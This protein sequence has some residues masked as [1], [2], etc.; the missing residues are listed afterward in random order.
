MA[1]NERLSRQL[2]ELV[3]QMTQ[4]TASVPSRE[5]AEVDYG[6][7]GDRKSDRQSIHFPAS[8]S[9]ATPV[10]P[11]KTALK[12]SASKTESPAAVRTTHTLFALQLPSFRSVKELT[13]AWSGIKRRSGNV[14]AGLEPRSFAVRDPQIGVAY[15]LIVGPMRN[16]GDAA[17]RCVR[18][19]EI[20]I[21]C[22]T[23]VFEGE[24]LAS[25]A[26]N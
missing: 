17:L 7:S 25:V 13:G 10:Q 6:V 11:E 9:S 19:G 16:A 23:T 22:E 4:V 14:L 12:A 15:R 26:N 18:L 20:G 5:I 8:S 2:D 3:T 21:P 24:P 1:T